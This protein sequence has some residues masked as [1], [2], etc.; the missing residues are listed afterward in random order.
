MKQHA[1]TNNENRDQHHMRPLRLRMAHWVTVSMGFL[2]IM[3]KTGKKYDDK[4][5]SAMNEKQLKTLITQ[6]VKL[7][8]AC[9]EFAV[10][11]NNHA[12]LL[13]HFQR[14][15]VG[16]NEDINTL[17]IAVNQLRDHLPVV[18]VTSNVR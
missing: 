18:K 13:A 17:A 15:I 1:K 2:S 16:L 6:N 7:A 5:G 10:I 11:I 14:E 4:E 12:T 3:Q 8:R 9:N